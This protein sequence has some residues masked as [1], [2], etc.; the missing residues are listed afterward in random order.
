MYK[1]LL[2]IAL[3]GCDRPADED[4]WRGPVPILRPCPCDCTARG[5]ASPAADTDDDTQDRRARTALPYRPSVAEHE[6]TPPCP[7]VDDAPLALKITQLMIDPEDMRDRDGEWIEIHNPEPLPADLSGVEIA[8]NGA[9]RCALPDVT[10]PA[11]SHV[12]IARDG[13]SDRLP[14]AGLSLRNSGGEVALVR[15]GEV[16][17]V[18]VWEK[19]PKGEAFRSAERSGRWPSR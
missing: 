17:D 19:A 15:R 5:D 9:L 7:P 8:I 18:M 10:L 12:L 3:V 14:C 13:A 6:P 16:I 11:F 1:L 2:L 4:C